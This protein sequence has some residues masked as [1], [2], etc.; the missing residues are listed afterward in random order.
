MRSPS[1]KAAAPL[2]FAAC[3]TYPSTKVLLAPP[4]AHLREADFPG[5]RRLAEIN[6][7]PGTSIPNRIVVIV[8]AVLGP[9]FVA[10]G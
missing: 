6:F 1:S 3:S 2:P 4:S 5:L 10:R 8:I 9:G 7:S